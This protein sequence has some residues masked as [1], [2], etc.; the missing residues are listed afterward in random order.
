MFRVTIDAYREEIAAAISRG[1]H[2]R[3]CEIA[4]AFCERCH[5]YKP[6]RIVNVRSHMCPLNGLLVYIDIEQEDAAP[7]VVAVGYFHNKRRL[8]VN[9]ESIKC[10]SAADVVH[11]LQV[12]CSFFDGIYY[13][14]EGIERIA[15]G[16]LKEQLLQWDKEAKSHRDAAARAWFSFDVANKAIEQAEKRAV[17]AERRLARAVESRRLVGNKRTW[18]ICP[19]DFKSRIVDAR[20]MVDAPHPEFVSLVDAKE[21]LSGKSGVYFGWRVT[22]GKCV[23][24]GKAKDLGKRLHPRREELKDCRITYLEMPEEDIHLWEPFFIWLHKPERNIETRMSDAVKANKASCI[25]ATVDSGDVTQKG[26]HDGSCTGD[27]VCVG[28]GR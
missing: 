23:Y 28:A 24:V 1:N 15:S 26:E 27:G 20:A 18:T 22:D 10:D 25:A 19:V 17:D 21:R 11:A 7:A 16:E 6:W 4:M 12:P 9:G 3:L 14:I 2:A 8:T 5:W 13:A